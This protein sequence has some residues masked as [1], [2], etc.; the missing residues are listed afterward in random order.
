MSCHQSHFGALCNFRIN[1]D[2]QSLY[3]PFYDRQVVRSAAPL[4]G[5]PNSPS[6]ECVESESSLGDLDDPIGCLTDASGDFE[7]P[8]CVAAFG[9]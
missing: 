1:R 3:A 4:E 7:S 5:T 2:A 6:R 9:L 8:Y